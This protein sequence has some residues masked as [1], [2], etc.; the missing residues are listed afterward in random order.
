MAVIQIS[1]IQHRR[2]LEQDFPQLAS[3]ELGWSLDTQRLFIGNGTL[4]EGAASEGVTEILTERSDIFSLANQYTF[5]GLS[6]GYQIVTGVDPN[7]PVVRSLQDKLD[8]TVS[9]KDFG[10]IGNSVADDTAAIQ[11]AM[12]RP[13]G[14]KLGTLI[15]FRHRTVNFPAGIY[16]ITDTLLIPPYIRLQGEGKTVSSIEGSFGGPLARCVDD[17]GQFGVNYGQPLTTT[18]KNSEYHFN[19]IQLWQKSLTSDQSCLI[20]DGGYTF[21]FNRCMFRGLLDDNIDPI[22]PNTDTYNF[23]RGSG[24]AGVFIPNE[25][26]YDDVKDV[27]FLQCDFY[28][29]NYGA[30]IKLAS[31]NISWS[32]CVFDHCYHGIVIGEVGQT[33]AYVPYAFSITS[34]YFRYTAREAVYCYEYINGVMSYGNQYNAAGL[35]S[36]VWDNGTVLSPV[37]T[38]NADYNFSIGDSIDRYQVQPAWNSTQ[39]EYDNFPPVQTNGYNCYV[40]T[41]DYGITNGQHTQGQAFKSTLSDSASYSSAG[42]FFLPRANVSYNDN[43]TIEYKIVHDGAVRTGVFRVLDSSGSIAWDDEYVETNETGVAL[44]AN[45]TTGDIEYTS[46][47]SGPAA[48][49]T[50]KINYFTAN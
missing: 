43:A 25:S 39:L 22:N 47:A 50:Y 21:T 26:N 42:I 10:A 18:P 33:T 8:D 48:S 36:G 17:F 45:T 23:D 13:V 6:A 38:F 16:R 4:S 15:N 31:H 41:R 46:I 30:E 28:G 2:G 1:R 7:S 34:N 3:A 14:N 44:R 27:K 20:I 19:D 37:I 35:G 9:V 40:W 32:Q 12:D 24:V 29:I 49:I 11:R 5:K